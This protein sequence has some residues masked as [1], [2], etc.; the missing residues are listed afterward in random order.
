MSTYYV[1]H[2]ALGTGD[3]NVK[4][5]EVHNLAR[6]NSLFCAYFFTGI[7]I[8][9]ACPQCTRWHGGGVVM[10]ESSQKLLHEG[11]AFWTHFWANKGFKDILE[12]KN[13]QKPL[14]RVKE[15]CFYFITRVGYM[16]ENFHKKL[17]ILRSIFD[18]G[19]TDSRQFV[20]VSQKHTNL[21]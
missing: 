15:A 7:S 13:T 11:G 19:R 9:E 20:L 5:Y 17:M 18:S 16:A 6:K 10:E 2:F 21:G 8:W 1:P 3:R 12:K 4:R 14:G